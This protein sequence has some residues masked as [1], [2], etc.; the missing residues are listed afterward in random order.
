M[1]FQWENLSKGLAKELAR[2]AGL[3]VSFSAKDLSAKFGEQPT[4]AVVQELWPVLR[5]RWLATRPVA[6]DR[7]VGDLRKAG[8][9]DTSIK[10]GSKTGKMDYLRSCRLSSRLKEI[11]L[12]AFL[13]EGSQPMMPPSVMVDSHP[14]EPQARDTTALTALQ[15]RVATIITELTGQPTIID[16]D[17]DIPFASGSARL[18]LSVLESDMPLPMV[19]VFGQLVQGVNSTHELLGDLN[20]ANQ[21]LRCCRLMCID[22][23]VVLNAFIPA[24]NLTIR[25][26]AFLLDEALSAADHFDTL[27]AARHG[28]KMLG[29]DRGEVLDA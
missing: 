15:S 14:D 23:M 19:R 18:F 11:V 9:G 25:E 10:I 27:F 6:R 22:G 5:D 16:G 20:E 24:D 3:R 28:G 21:R 17:G 12:A 1:A 7:V 29:S 4:D 2:V 26:L 8:L 13:A